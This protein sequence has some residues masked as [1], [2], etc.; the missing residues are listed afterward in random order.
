MEVTPIP[1]I[2][3]SIKDAKRQPQKLKTDKSPGLDC[4]HPRIL[5]ELREELGDVLVNLFNTLL[6]DGR[7]PN[8]WK[9]ANVSAIYKKVESEPINYCPVSLTSVAR[10]IMESI[11]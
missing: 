8:N 2:I 6:Q 3:I 5:V 7:L 4:I 10:K 11:L 1:Y 9:I